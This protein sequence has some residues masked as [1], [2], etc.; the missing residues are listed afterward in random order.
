MKVGRGDKGGDK[1]REA[2]G[3][4]GH[5]RVSEEFSFC[6][7]Q[8]CAVQ[9]RFRGNEAPMPSPLAVGSL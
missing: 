2:P 8:Y 1:S 6:A 3:R 7:P 9:A 5:T 4:G